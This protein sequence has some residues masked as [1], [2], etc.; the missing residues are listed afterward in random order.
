[1][2]PNFS[3]E[4][5]S[6]QENWRKA[7]ISTTAKGFQ[8][9]KDYEHI[10]PKK[11]WHETLWIDIRKDLLSYLKA[12]NIQPHTGTHNLSS[13]WVVC[14]NLYF[15]VRQNANL[16][17]LMLQFLQQKVSP[18]ITSVTDIELEF[19]FD[20]T[21][22]LSPANLL[23][24]LGGSRGTGQTSPDVAFLITTEVGNGII[25]TECKFTEH[26]FYGCS[27][28]KIDNK[29][30]RVNN[31]DPSRCMNKVSGIDFKAVCHQTI[32]GRKYLDLITFSE[33][34]DNTITR[35]PA[36]TGGYQLLRQQALAEGIASSGQY[37]LV[38]SAVAF[39]D[40]N[41]DLKNCLKSTGINDF[42]THWADLFEGKAIFRTW[43]HQE[44]VDFIRNK[45]TNGE[46]D[47]W[48]N[49]LEQR[50]GY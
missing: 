21:N 37:D 13:S 38:A 31:P 42:Q 44:W 11:N 8:N 15:P 5:R 49:Y 35:C 19:A 28:R 10:V 27:A 29:S 1:M 39:D 20:E 24:E 43:K 47:K 12:K 40:R 22:L 33:K 45:Q 14:A 30:T 23:G 50:Y 2:K 36:A 18:Q 46:F 7:N 32:W 4:Q 48:L 9:G 3:L 16:K 41:N 34:A 25:L 17:R 6:Q 26:S